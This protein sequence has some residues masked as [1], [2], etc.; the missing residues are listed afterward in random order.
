M[1][2]Q[3]QLNIQELG[4]P[5]DRVMSP[6]STPTLSEWQSIVLKDL[7]WIKPLSPHDE[8]LKPH[9]LSK[10]TQGTLQFNPKD[11]RETFGTC[12]PVAP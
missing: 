9:S 7:T 1:P 3:N 2:L 11:A 4:L 10:E 8:T 6:L 12:P 5:R